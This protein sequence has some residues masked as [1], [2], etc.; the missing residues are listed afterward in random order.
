[1]KA[2]GRLYWALLGIA[3]VT[4]VSGV[5]QA[6]VP[7]L[8]LRRLASEA[9]PAGLHFFAIV[10]MFMVLFGGMLL[11]ALL[12]PSH[13]PVAVLWASFQ[14]FG[15]AAAVGLGVRN[16]VFGSLALSVAAFDL[17]SGM[18]AITYWLS[19]KDSP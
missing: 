7:G 9:T 1:M 19:L 13:H 8:I 18:L 4:M 10:G 16:E 11:H 6:A 2:R 14:K 17:V 5:A 15:A 3:A 12:S